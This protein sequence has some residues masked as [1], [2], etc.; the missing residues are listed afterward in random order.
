[1]NKFGFIAHPIDINSFYDFLGVWNVFAKILSEKTIKNIAAKLPPYKLCSLNKIRSSTGLAVSADV[2]AIPLL[3]IQ[4]AT[5]DEARVL[6]LIEK[7]IRMCERSG[8]RIVGLGGFASVVGNE[9]QVLSDR[10]DVPLTSGNTMTAAL[11]LEG[12]YKAARLMDIDLMDSVVAIIG[13]TGDIGSIC[14]KILSKKVKKVNIAARNEKKLQEFAKLITNY[15][16]AKVEVFRYSKDAIK[17]ADIILTAT[18]AVTT[19]IE[20][21]QLKSGSVV[22]DVAIP[23]NIVREVVKARDDVL[24]FEGGLA[25]IAHMEDV[26]NK[27][28]SHLVPVN[29]IYGCVSETMALTLEGRF[30]PYSIG[31]GNI[32]EEKIEEIKN[33]AAKHG[34]VLSDF[35]CGYKFFTNKDIEKI[36]ENALKHRGG[37]HVS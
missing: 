22:C 4:I 31:R 21:M 3:P 13:A 6:S 17:D 11:T 29:G 35:F 8:A 23:A 7:G 16:N 30:E 12:I 34:I 18:S 24:V 9:G 25:K 36:K 5:F 33:I 26:K 19:V 15:G 2:I 37:K 1:M 14:T 10:V 32:T 27:K 20:P 28:L